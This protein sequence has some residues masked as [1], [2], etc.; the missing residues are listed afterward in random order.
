M[1]FKKEYKNLWIACS[2]TFI[3]AII[4]FLLNYRIGKHQFFLLLNND[5]GFLADN[6]FRFYTNVGD[7]IVWAVL[8]FVFIKFRKKYLPLL[9]SAF[10]ISTVLVQI[11]KYLILPNE[12]RPIAAINDTELIHTV[13]AIK[14]HRISTFPSG[15]T[16]AA[17]C[18]F[19]IACVVIKKNWL[20]PVGFISAL[21]VGY[22]R[23]YLAQHF[24]FD[25]AAGM[26]TAI[27]SVCLAMLIQQ[28]WSHKKAYTT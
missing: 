21:L 23:V 8:L 27:I 15:H 28:W 11:C 6:F 17:F 9:I 1:F 3:T 10:I 22:S 24:P 13:A 12:P 4:L 16:A 5:L 7:G 19:L 25:V 18:F 2:L 26:I 14:P 20:L